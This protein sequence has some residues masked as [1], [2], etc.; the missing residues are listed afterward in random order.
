[1]MNEEKEKDN[2]LKKLNAGGDNR[3]LADDGNNRHYWYSII[4]IMTL[5]LHTRQGVLQYNNQVVPGEEFLAIRQNQNGIFLTDPYH[6]AN[7]TEYFND[8]I[9]RILGN[10]PEETQNNHVW[11]TMPRLIV[12]PLLSGMHWRTIAIQINYEIYTIDIVW[13]DPYGKFPEQL[14]QN[15]LESIKINI[16]KLLNSNNQLINMG[17]NVDSLIETDINIL[18]HNNEIDQQ[19]QGQNGWDCGPITVSNIRDYIVHYAHNNNNL[20][21]IDY[22]VSDYNTENHENTIKDIRINHI[23][24]YGT[25]TGIGI[26]EERLNDIRLIWEKNNKAQLQQIDKKFYKEISQL[27]DFYL[28][29]FFSVLQN[30]Q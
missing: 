19:G 1:M 4:D 8:D 30:Y 15:L 25:V 5:L 22:T 12:I 11:D 6:T 16:L 18:Q 28:S 27:D 29:I 3:N 7:F 26:D 2:K 10:H 20:T 17:E 23:K 9:S 14:K 21:G 13:D 24:Q